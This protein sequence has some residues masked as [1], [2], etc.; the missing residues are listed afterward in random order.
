MIEANIIP[1]QISK[2]CSIYNQVASRCYVQRD[3]LSFSGAAT[4]RRY[5]G[6]TLRIVNK[7]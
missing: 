5:S 4:I 2:K 7:V 6:S 1:S 3:D